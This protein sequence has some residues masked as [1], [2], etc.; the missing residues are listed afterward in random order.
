MSSEQ[1]YKTKLFRRSMPILWWTKRW[2]HTKFILREL[3]SLCVAFFSLELILLVLSISK[4]QEEYFTFIDTLGNP[5]LIILN[6]VAFIGL[7][8]HSITW[9]DL[10]PKAM[11]I[12]VGSKPLPAFIISGSNYVGWIVLSVLIFWILIL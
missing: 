10:A 5:V 4:G 1:T 6:I 3:T 9:F 7:I 12:K 8:F 2:S 11:V